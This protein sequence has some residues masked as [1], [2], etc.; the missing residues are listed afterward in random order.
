VKVICYL[1]SNKRVLLCIVYC[2]VCMS[3]KLFFMFIRYEIQVGE[4]FSVGSECCYV[5]LMLL[6]NLLAQSD[7]K[8]LGVGNYNT[9]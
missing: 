8:N 2:F 9:V 4:C 7:W 6:V 1:W 3:T 5:M